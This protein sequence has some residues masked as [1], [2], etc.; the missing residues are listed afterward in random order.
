M[1]KVTQALLGSRFPTEAEPELLE[2]LKS[3]AKRSHGPG[4]G[5]GELPGISCLGRT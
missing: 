3:Q 4:M 2:T 5:V 1:P